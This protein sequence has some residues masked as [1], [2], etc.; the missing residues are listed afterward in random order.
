MAK[1]LE[2]L[3]EN[4]SRRITIFQLQLKLHDIGRGALPDLDLK[5]DIDAEFG[6]INKSAKN[7]SDS[8][9]AETHHF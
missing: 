6:L 1:N 4:L 7:I 9:D 5:D 2:G 3:Q 8:F